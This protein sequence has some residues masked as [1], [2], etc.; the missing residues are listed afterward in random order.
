MVCEGA[1]R[2]SL[3]HGPR[4]MVN[5]L[6]KPGQQLRVARPDGLRAAGD[7]GGLA[8]R[9]ATT[10]ARRAPVPYRG[11]SH[12]PVVAPAG[13]VC[14]RPGN[15]QALTR[16]SHVVDLPPQAA[17]RSDAPARWRGGADTIRCV[18]PAGR[19]LN[20]ERT[21]KN[22]R[23]SRCENRSL[24]T[25]ASSISPRF[26]HHLHHHQGRL[27][28][29]VQGHGAATGR[30]LTRTVRHGEHCRYRPSRIGHHHPRE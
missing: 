18:Y 23:F 1:S 25:Y 5:N 30:P 9:L 6:T 11:T 22:P 14:G 26:E 28:V 8:A 24:W 2:R 3:C 16:A 27:E 13:W 10:G 20:V 29:G 12:R 19:V 15:R 4:R 21:G 17:T 7:V